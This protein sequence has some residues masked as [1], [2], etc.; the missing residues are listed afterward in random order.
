V[1]SPS[2]LA[3][4]AGEAERA[5]G[6]ELN[7][8][9]SGKGRVAAALKSAGWVVT[10]TPAVGTLARH[11]REVFAALDVTCVIDV[12]ANE[13]QYARMLRDEVG[14]QGRIASV[15]PASE[16][17]ARL[18]E[19]SAADPDWVTFNFGLGDVE[20]TAVLHT[21]SNDCFSS[22]HPLNNYGSERFGEH[23]IGT[24]TVTVHRLDAVFDELTGGSSRIFLKSDTQGNDLSVIAGLGSHRVL[25]VQL[26]LS[27]MSIYD[28][29]PDC[30]EALTTLKTAGFS[31][32]GF[33]PIT[34]AADGLA[35]IEADGVFVAESSLS[36][37]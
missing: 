3:C 33:Y 13:G 6:V 26:E 5:G 21:L 11:L 37:Q 7:A 12:G 20:G 22:F 25:G 9:A 10:R 18:K 15:E 28:G 29:A 34:R 32:T 19:A 8:M 36:T 17:F 24:E 27:F 4:A 1:S 30:I 35:L 2:R 31:P 16:T 14:F 23:E